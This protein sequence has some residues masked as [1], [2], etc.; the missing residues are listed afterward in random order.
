MKR[1]FLSVIVAL[2][3]TVLMAGGLDKVVLAISNVSTTTT[4]ASQTTIGKITGFILRVDVTFSSQ[5][6]SMFPKVYASNDFTGMTTTILQP[7]QLGTNKTYYPKIPM[8]NTSGDTVATNQ[9]ALIPLLEETIYLETTNSPSP[10]QD[11]RCTVIYQR[12]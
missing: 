11:I 12:P 1:F 5:T 3:G 9:M 2:C 6:N 7:G 8:Q 4:A 10:S